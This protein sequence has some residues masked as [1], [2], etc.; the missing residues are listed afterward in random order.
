MLVYTTKITNRF[1]FVLRQMFV[2]ILEI[3]I[4]FTSSLDEFVA[5]SGPK[6]SYAPESLGQEFHVFATGFL[7]EQ[8]IS[9]RALKTGV[10]HDYPVIFAHAKPS[11]IPFDIFSASF[12]CLTRYEEYLPHIKDEEGCFP[13]HQSWVFE[14]KAL[15]LPL[16]DLW[17]VRFLALL[18][19]EFPE[20]T[21]PQKKSKATSISYFEIQSPLKY[22]YKTRL[23][24]WYQFFQSIWKL[25]LLD[26]LEQVFVELHLIKDPHDNYEEILTQIRQQQSKA[27]FY[28][29]FSQRSIN[30]IATAIYNTRFHS[31]IKGVSDYS[32]TT[33]LLSENAQ[34]HEDVL[35]KEI[36][37][38]TKLIHRPIKRSRFQG[39]LRSIS[40]AYVN[41]LQQEVLH[42]LSMGYEK[43][44]GY[45]ASTAVAF[46]YYDL[47]NEYQTPLMIHPVVATEKG[48]REFSCEEAFSKLSKY[49][50]KLPTTT[51]IQRVF[52][53]NL[54]WQENEENEQWRLEFFN[55]LKKHANS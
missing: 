29:L 25:N 20:W 28:F 30:R 11:K 10:W 23:S 46:Y 2:R 32:L 1:Q 40:K 24:K 9:Y 47:E 54:I 49:E 6:F 55:Y 37:N 38:L 50:D 13:A 34:L 35:G 26:A 19:E 5:F 36:D 39:G 3:P 27:E 48:L 22:F 4:A 12:Y 14:Q 41:L 18:Q 16:V 31:L 45:R 52:F 7:Q 21:P 43:Q 8:G 33:S 42:D 44:V 53:S 15:E 17:A 51:A